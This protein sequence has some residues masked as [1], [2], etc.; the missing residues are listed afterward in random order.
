MADHSLTSM[1]YTLK[2]VKLA[3][4]SI[5]MERKYQDENLSRGIVDLVLTARDNWK[6]K[7]IA[8]E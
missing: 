4:K 6:N 1:K 5:D 8:N 2:A 3:D 7:T